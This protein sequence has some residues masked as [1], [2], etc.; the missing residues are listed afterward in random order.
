MAREVISTSILMIATVVAVTAAIMVIL[1]AV[2]DL[3]HSY[4]SV[5]GNL[6]ERVETD[7]EIIFIK[8]TNTSTTVNVYF[9]VKNTGSTRLDTDL[10]RLSDIFFTSNS[11]YLHYTGSDSDVSFT[12]ENGDGDNYWEKGETLK[13]AV[14]NI[15]VAQMPQDEYLLTFVLY[16]GVRANDYFSW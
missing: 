15:N 12:I 16:N 1:P 14:E 4:T 3:A 7:M 8:V 11:A 5:S 6:N 13:F 9:W 10:I 2:K